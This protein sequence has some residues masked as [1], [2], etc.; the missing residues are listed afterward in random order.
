MY[1][2]ELVLKIHATFWVILNHCGYAEKCIFWVNDFSI[3]D[4]HHA[5][6]LSY[7]FKNWNWV[8]C[9]FGDLFPK[10]DSDIFPFIWQSIFRSTDKRIKNSFIFYT[11][12]PYGNGKKMIWF[13]SS[14]KKWV[15]CRD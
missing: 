10:P 8:Y 7:N 6:T 4:G 9:L 1:L 11:Q 2:G 12:A 15:E 14:K 13:F 5:V 3:G